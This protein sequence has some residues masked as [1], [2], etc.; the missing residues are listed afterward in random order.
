M[1]ILKKNMVYAFCVALLVGLIFSSCSEDNMDPFVNLSTSEIAVEYDGLLGTGANASFEIGSDAAWKITYIEDWIICN[2]MS[3]A[4]GRTNVFLTIEENLTGE[5]REG[6]IMIE[7]GG[8][9]EGILVTQSLKVETLSATP[10]KL[11][12][13]KSGLTEK[14]EEASLYV[15]TNCEWKITA[16]PEWAVPEKTEG[17]RGSFALKL[18]IPENTTGKSRT[19]EI[20]FEA[21]DLTTKVEVTQSLFEIKTNE[22]KITVN[23]LGFL[24]DESSP[25]IEVTAATTWT[26]TH[27]SWIHLNKTTGEPG[28]DKVVLTFDEN[29][30]PAKRIGKVTFT[31][32][33]NTI[34]EVEVTQASNVTLEDDG[35]AIGF[36]YLNED[37]SWI[38]GNYVSDKGDPLPNY[39][40]DFAQSS[41]PGIESVLKVAANA[42]LAQKWQQQGWTLY[43]KEGVAISAYF[44]IGAVKFGT[45][46]R[47]GG[48]IL[49]D[50]GLGDGKKTTISLS[51]EILNNIVVK[52]KDVSSSTYGTG[53]PD[54]K[55]MTIEILGPGTFEDGTTTKD[56]EMNNAKWNDWQAK[57]TKIKDISSF[58]QVIFRSQDMADKSRWY[59]DNVKVTKSN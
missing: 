59:L 36:E 7:R 28:I 43:K 55:Y 3:G 42:V 49:P 27:D 53:D 19:G 1:T 17:K 37:F 6:I 20:I 58:T 50:L 14:G 41:T 52:D 38:T 16:Y 33:E 2:H 51:F 31:T 23:G 45:S 11:A 8:I 44:L 22:T 21:G 9:T 46:S 12:I 29:T 10:A 39:L 34:V 24:P 18:T 54:N 57:T 32:P 56:F 48:I 47:G 35:K 30:N 15:M 40:A 25:E 5:D 13:A 4:K 26:A